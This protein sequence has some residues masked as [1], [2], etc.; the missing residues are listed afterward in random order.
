MKRVILVIFCCLHLFIMTWMLIVMRNQRHCGI[1]SEFYEVNRNLTDLK[2][3]TDI[4]AGDL[5]KIRSDVGDIKHRI[6]RKGGLEI[7]EPLNK[8]K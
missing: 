6:E 2:Y 1:H 3:S 5:E 4:I 8:E 7:S